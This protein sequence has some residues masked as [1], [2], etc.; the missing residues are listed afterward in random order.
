MMYGSWRH[1]QAAKIEKLGRECK[2]FENNFKIQKD[3]SRMMEI[4]RYEDMAN[5]PENTTKLIYNFLNLEM[6]PEI[7]SFLQNST[8][9]EN[10]TR[11]VQKPLIFVQ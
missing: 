11:V 3:F 9:N 4:V 10:S 6:S 8:Q 5:D 1:G 7:S 2:N